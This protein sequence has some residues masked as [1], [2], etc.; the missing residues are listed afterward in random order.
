[1]QTS[2]VQVRVRQT[3]PVDTVSGQADAS[4]AGGPPLAFYWHRTKISL[5]LQAPKEGPGAMVLCLP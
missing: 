2:E 4:D 1:M 5:M 3:A